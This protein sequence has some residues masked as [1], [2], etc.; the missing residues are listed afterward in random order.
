MRTEKKNSD[1][2]IVQNCSV[3]VS[4]SLMQAAKS[5]CTEKKKKKIYSPNESHIKLNRINVKG[6]LPEEQTLINAGRPYCSTAVTMENIICKRFILYVT[7]PYT[8]DSRLII[9]LYALR[10]RI[11][12]K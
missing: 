12:S 10:R 2:N 6:G 4:I 3:S 8:E 5:Y 9:A 7:T 11:Y 1:S